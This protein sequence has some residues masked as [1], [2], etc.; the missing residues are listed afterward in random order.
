MSQKISPNKHERLIATEAI[1][2]LKDHSPQLLKNNTKG[3][4]N[5]TIEEEAISIEIPR[6]VFNVLIATLEN[7]ASGKPVNVQAT[8]TILTTQQVAYRLGVSRPF[9]VKL[10][11]NNVMPF[12]RV[13][14]HRRVK[15]G[16][17]MGY[18][19]HIN[20]K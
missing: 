6:K 19:S 4:L 11:E 2:F 13:G 1:R 5:L 7:M 17:V 12:T 20:N 18:E 9:V 3:T 10:L 14:K 15:L 8:D 16:D